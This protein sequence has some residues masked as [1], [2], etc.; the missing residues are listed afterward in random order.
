MTL[1]LEQDENGSYRA[2]G[3]P[4]EAHTNAPRVSV[5]RDEARILM[6]L[7]RG[8]DVIE[9]GTGLGVSAQ[10]LA[11]H[12]ARVATIDPDPWVEEH[13]W[14][15]LKGYAINPLRSM[16]ELKKRYRDWGSHK[17]ELA[18]IDGM[19]DCESVTR[20]IE[21]VVPYMML[22]CLIVLHDFNHEPVRKAAEQFGKATKIE[23]H[24]GIGL[25][26]VDEK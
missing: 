18:F 21:S 3:D 24:H 17:F 16:D 15:M 2:K 25:L 1:E 9:I 11:C 5:T 7:A 4:G 14:P 19:H 10:A 22:G 20:D 8:K 23:T 26:W 6:E 13:V 12:A